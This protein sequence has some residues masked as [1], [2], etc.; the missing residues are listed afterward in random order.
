MFA[1]RKLLKY[2][3]HFIGLCVISFLPLIFAGI[4]LAFS[5]PSSA[6]KVAIY[7]VTLAIALISIGF[8]GWLS[9]RRLSRAISR[10]NSQVLPANEVDVVGTPVEAFSPS[11]QHYNNGD[12]SPSGGHVIDMPLHNTGGSLGISDSSIPPVPPLPG[13]LPPGQPVPPPPYQNNMLPPVPRMDMPMPPPPA[14]HP[15]APPAGVPPAPPLPMSN[16]SVPK[17]TYNPN[18]YEQH[19]SMDAESENNDDEVQLYSF[20]T[21]KVQ[22]GRS[23]GYAH[24]PRLSQNG[25]VEDWVNTSGTHNGNGQP[26]GGQIHGESVYGPTESVYEQTDSVQGQ[27]VPAASSVDDLFEKMLESYTDNSRPSTNASKLPPPSIPLPN[28]M[29]NTNSSITATSSVDMQ[30]KEDAK[31]KML[32]ALKQESRGTA[33]GGHRDEHDDF[34]DSD[35]DNMSS[36]GVSPMT[37][38]KSDE[39]GG[40]DGKW[41]PTSVNFEN[42]AAHIAEALNQPDGP[43][44]TLRALRVANDS[45]DLD[46]PSIEVHTP[47]IS[48]RRAEQVTT[49]PGQRAVVHTRP[50]PPQPPQQR[51]EIESMTSSTTLDD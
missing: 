25:Y 22:P 23:Q 1:D 37:Q 5:N 3:F 26:H 6:A 8:S 28:L 39:Y 27:K 43:Q 10:R 16:S 36:R 34:L 15:P 24:S 4:A 31:R 38:R 14:A 9:Y 51:M 48:P 29:S 33:A 2:L 20:E 35:S 17:P 18:G 41:K 32:N 44:N 45:D 30:R 46:T 21:I 12:Q 11:Q 47:D 7:M 49:S 19:R 13:N 50:L 40:A 42:I